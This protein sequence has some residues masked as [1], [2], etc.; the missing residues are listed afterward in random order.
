FR[1]RNGDRHRPFGAGDH[2]GQG[3]VLV[4][5]VGA[6]VAAGEDD[7]GDA[8]RVEDAG[9]AAAAGGA[10]ARLA[11]EPAPRCGGDAYGNAV[12]GVVVG[13]VS[14]AGADLAGGA[15]LFSRRL[16]GE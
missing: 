6:V 4:D 11:A 2:V 15:F 16:E 14:A 1:C 12:L 9:I 8:A 5:R 3:D 7:G 10:E 13:G